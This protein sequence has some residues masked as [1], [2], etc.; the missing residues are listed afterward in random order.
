MS[1]TFPTS[2]CQSHSCARGNKILSCVAFEMLERKK[3]Q[4]GL[5][6]LEASFSASET[7]RKLETSDSRMPVVPFL[8]GARWGDWGKRCLC[9]N[10]EVEGGG[11]GKLETNRNVSQMDSLAFLLEYGA[12]DKVK[13]Q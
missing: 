8:L 13:R 9:Q 2:Y 11:N 7:K 4:I 12:V 6:L 10:V 1:S 3:N 5:D